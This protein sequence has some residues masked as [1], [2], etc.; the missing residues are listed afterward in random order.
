[1]PKSDSVYYETLFAFSSFPLYINSSSHCYP[2]DMI[3]NVIK[4][5]KSCCI[6][7]KEFKNVTKKRKMETASSGF[8]PKK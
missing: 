8:F 7:H 5:S 3:S 2:V 6:S 4:S 1:M